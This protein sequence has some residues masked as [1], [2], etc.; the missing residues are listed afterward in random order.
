[1]N[2]ATLA[3]IRDDLDHLAPEP[4]WQV[5][6]TLT[7]PLASPLPTPRRPRITS[8]PLTRYHRGTSAAAADAHRRRRPRHLHNMKDRLL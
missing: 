5:I 7:C 6:G 2:L 4:W 8:H 1:M 3:L